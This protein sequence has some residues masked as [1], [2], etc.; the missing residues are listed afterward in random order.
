MLTCPLAS[1]VARQGA[2]MALVL[3]AALLAPPCALAQSRTV[4]DDLGRTLT[5][6]AP[7]SRIIS[8]AP[9]LTEIIFALD[10]GERIVATVEYSDYPPQA[11][12]IKRLGDAFAVSVEAVVA[13]SPDL[14]VAWTTGGSQTSL[15][16]LDALGYPIY[17]NEP[18]SLAS[19][20]ATLEKLG[21]LLGKEQLGASQARAFRQRL[22]GLRQTYATAEPDRVFY[23]IA[24]ARLFTV[25]AEHQIGEALEVCGAVNI[26][27]GLPLP[28]PIVSLESLVAA[29][30]ELIVVSRSYPGQVSGWEPTWQRLGWLSRIRYVDGSLISRS[31]PRMLDGVA[32]LCEVLH[33]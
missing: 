13:A 2:V 33:E 10:A 4:L 11:T 28:V 27:A 15:A 25:S 20:A 30:P 22:A 31:G 12:T 14:I 17:F 16:R 32:Q 29:D 5:L 3:A 7:P 23:Q 21:A 18:T 24:D 8:L 6:P 26:F 1:A 9:H 19:I